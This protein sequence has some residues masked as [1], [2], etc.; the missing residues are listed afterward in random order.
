[1]SIRLKLDSQSIDT[2]PNSDNQVT[3]GFSSFCFPYILWID[4]SL[5]IPP[6]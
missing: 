1:M 2:I 4:D 6:L 5:V 3:L